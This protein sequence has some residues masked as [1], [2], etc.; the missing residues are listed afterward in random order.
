MASL[1][2]LAFTDIV[3]AQAAAIQARSSQ[4]I[5]LT[6]GS[7]LRAIVEANAGVVLWLQGLVVY[8]LTLTRFSTSQGADA[9]SW[10]ADFGFARLPAVPAT[11]QVTFTRFTTTDQSV[12][13]F[14]TVLQTADGTQTFTVNTDSTNS[15]YNAGLGGY[16]IAANVATLTVSVT[17]SSAGSS[18]NVLANT[19]TSMGQGVPGVD[20]VTNGA[21]FTNGIDAESDPAY[22]ARF[23]LWIASL[24]K[25][26][27]AAVASAVAGVQQGLQSTVTE[28][29]D[30]NGT[31]D[32]G[33]FYTIVDD[34]T[35]YPS[36]GLISSVSAA[37]EATRALGIRFSVFAPVVET[38][39]VT[40]EITS[41]SGYTHSTVVANVQTAI[42]SFLNT[43]PLGAGL[44]YSQLYAIAYGVAGVTNVSGLLLNSGTSDIAPN[45]KD[46]IK[47]ATISVS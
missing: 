1:S 13:P 10:G 7:V 11:G 47:A 23:V 29:Y 42:T 31:Y 32:P 16:V 30:Y 43:I 26:T 6:V 22:K 20:T 45:A 40:L 41:A 36:S 9:D 14:G 38:A 5:N 27:A 25:G 17:A 37:I 33:F 28:D 12:V 21:A 39:N 46:V 24:S 44:A 15:A 18:G 3:R 8:L 2:T 19:I 34:G 4:L 35:G